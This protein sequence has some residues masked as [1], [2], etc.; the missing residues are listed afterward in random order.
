MKRHVEF[1]HLEFLIAFVE[2]IVF[3]TI[4]LSHKLW[5]LVPVRAI[6]LRNQPKNI[7]K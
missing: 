2:K 1:E 3:M 7:P 5:L 4:S 6:G